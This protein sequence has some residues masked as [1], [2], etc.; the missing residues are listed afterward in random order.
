MALLQGADSNC[1]NTPSHSQALTGFQKKVIADTELKKKVSFSI[2]LLHSSFTLKRLPTRIGLSP[3]P[4]VSATL[5][6]WVLLLKR[7]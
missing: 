6:S 7:H 3:A 5:H 1:S 2:T 4:G